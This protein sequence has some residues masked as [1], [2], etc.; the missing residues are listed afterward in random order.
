[1]QGGPLAGYRVVEFC[2][3]LAGPFATMLMA[4]QGA[5]VVKVET[6]QGD[7]SR[8]VG[9]TRAGMA[10]LFLNV[11]R[12][13]RSVV[14]DLKTD[15][16]LTQAL[17]LAAQ[18][19]V[20]VQNY[21][22]GV[23]DRLGLGYDAVRAL[24]PDTVYVS[25]SGLGDSGPGRDRRVYDIVVQGLTGFCTVQADRDTGEPRTVQ[26][27]VADKIASLSVWQA[28]TAALLHRER[29]GQGQ[30]VKVNMLRAVLAFVWPEAMPSA[31]FVGGGVRAGGNFSKVR[32]VF[33]TA[34][35][36]ILC[37]FVSNDEFAAVARA[38][39]LPDLPG[40]P[41]F[42]TIGKRFANAPALNAILAARLLARPTAEW[43]ARLGAEDAVFAPVNGPDTIPD[44]P[45]IA[46]AGALCSHEH[47]VYGPYRQPAHPVEFGAT[48]A[49][50]RRHAP[51]LG[52]HTDEVLA[53]LAATGAV[54]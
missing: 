52:E 40:D 9:A 5:D 43:L 2:S 27:A 35:G 14:L 10:T 42:D 48:P 37:G 18:A 45:L 30:H 20:I 36:H 50:H 51:L 31:T 13:K 32:Y 3:T 54:A 47:P 6:P 29:T 4:D 28:A 24:R 17:R 26:N 12:N 1:M 7:Q 25:V 21:R 44:D 8:Q 22:P 49:A 11:N 33:A 53:E 46:A 23:M 39:D 16:G 38:L 15:A 19:D 34:D 41:R